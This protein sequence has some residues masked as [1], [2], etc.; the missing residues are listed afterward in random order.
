MS[1][2]SSLI[3]FSL[4]LLFPNFFDKKEEEKGG[5]LS[6][7]TLETNDFA[8]KSDNNA[9]LDDDGSARNNFVGGIIALLDSSDVRASQRQTKQFLEK[10]EKKKRNLMESIS[11]CRHFFIKFMPRFFNGLRVD[12]TTSPKNRHRR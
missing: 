9:Q 5:V 2:C 8:H 4:S 10:E 3:F 11:R 6:C 12:T 1:G 7:F